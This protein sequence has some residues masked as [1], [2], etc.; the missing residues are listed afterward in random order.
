M[1]LKTKTNLSLFL[2]IIFIPYAN[3]TLQFAIT[4]RSTYGGQLNG[5]ELNDYQLAPL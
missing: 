1:S 2:Q 4:C 3:N 5:R